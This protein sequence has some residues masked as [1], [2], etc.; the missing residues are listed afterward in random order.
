MK[1]NYFEDVMTDDITV[2]SDNPVRSI[3]ISADYIRLETQLAPLSVSYDRRYSV[4][5]KTNCVNCGAPLSGESMCRY[6][7]TYNG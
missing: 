1:N 6:C 3:T 4:S 2:S 5:Q 7:D